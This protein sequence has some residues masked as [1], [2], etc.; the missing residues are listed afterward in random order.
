MSI[1][2]GPRLW[3]CAVL[4]SLSA[5]GETTQPETSASATTA[6]ADIAI[7]NITAIDTANG[8]REGVTV[9][10]RDDQIIAVATAEEPELPA[11]QSIDGRGR[12]LIPGLWDM[13]VHI[14]Y[15]PELTDLMPLLF[16]DY[17][18]TSVRDTGGM[19]PEGAD[20]V[21]MI[22]HTAAIDEQTIE[23]YRQ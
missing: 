13:H 21:V 8:V 20:G 11:D 2:P 6:A 3:A 12:Y 10:T 4:L 5:C 17:G 18:I 9:Y 1:C 22:E 19:L 7:T 14:T 23:A 15:E 16:L